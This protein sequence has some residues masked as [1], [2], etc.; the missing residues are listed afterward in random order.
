MSVKEIKIIEEVKKYFDG[1][2]VNARFE[3]AGDIDRLY[4]STE[5]GANQFC[6]IE[7]GEKNTISSKHDYINRNFPLNPELKTVE[8]NGDIKDVSKRVLCRVL[9]DISLLEGKKVS[10]SD[11]QYRRDIVVYFNSYSLLKD[12][13]FSYYSC[14]GKVV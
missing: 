1:T 6:V 7:G 12:D 5:Y 13:K 8:G 4:L 3:H 11:I 10:L 14:V 2:D 9:E